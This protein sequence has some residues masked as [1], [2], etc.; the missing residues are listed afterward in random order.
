MLQLR[1]RK[2]ML[3]KPGLLSDDVV[4]RRDLEPIRCGHAW[5]EAG[6]VVGKEQGA[7]VR[8]M[9]KRKE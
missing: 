4:P 1:W 8:I 3:L 9:G 7:A 6:Q 2:R 5:R